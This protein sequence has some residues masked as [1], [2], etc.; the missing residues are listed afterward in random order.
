M[1][2]FLNL[3]DVNAVYR[4]ELISAFIS[5][6]D[7]GWFIQGNE[8]SSFE[9]EFATYCGTKYCVGVAN[10]LDALILTLKAWKLMGKIKDGDEVIVPGNTFIA[11]ILAISECGLVPVFV[12]PD[13]TTYNISPAA[14]KSNL[15]NKTRV[16]L[17]V[18]LYGQLSDMVQIQ[19]LAV[20]YGLLVLEDCAQAHGAKLNNLD[21]RAGSFGD[22]GAFSFYPGKNLGALGDAGAI[23]TNDS[24]LYQVLL[25]LRNYGSEVKYK[26]IIKGVN[27]RLDELQAAFLRIKL[28]NIEQD[29]HRRREISL[30]YRNEINNNKVKLGSSILPFGEESHVWHLFVIEV[31]ERDAFINHMSSHG[32]VTAI[33]YPTAPH[34]Q[35]AYK[36]YHHISLPVTEQIHDSILSLPM[37]PTLTDE[38]INC[39]ISAVN[40]F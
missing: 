2:D 39:V 12:E 30:R 38:D 21:K 9:N 6:L 3:K 15:T 20:E 34:K 35:D 22:A 36:E 40:S 17:P 5:V 28:S 1:V 11:S 16:I 8:V 24:E 29:T 32:V 26:H 14:I 23:T 27:S 18:H 7:R 33:H 37:S 19:P 31:K 4:E 10:G 13:P 25:A